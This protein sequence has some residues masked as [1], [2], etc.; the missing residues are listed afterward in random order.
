MVLELPPDDEGEEAEEMQ[1][2]VTVIGDRFLVFGGPEEDEMSG[3]VW[4]RV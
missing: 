2:D 1:W 3:F 4:E